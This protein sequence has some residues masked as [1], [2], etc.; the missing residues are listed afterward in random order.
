MG[1]H[2]ETAGERSEARTRAKQIRDFESHWDGAYKDT[3]WVGGEFTTT[4]AETGHD[5]VAK[6]LTDLRDQARDYY[7]SHKNPYGS[8]PT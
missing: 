1:P 8:S 7:A 2:G 3:A 5:L 6:D 4:H